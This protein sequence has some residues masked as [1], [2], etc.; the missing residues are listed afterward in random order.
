MRTLRA[1]ELRLPRAKAAALLLSIVM[2]KKI[3]EKKASIATTNQK[4]GRT[5]RP[6]RLRS[7]GLSGRPSRPPLS[8]TVMS[9]RKRQAVSFSLKYV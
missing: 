6:R 2:M 9:N 3:P 8:V 5:M 4:K 7:G 1:K